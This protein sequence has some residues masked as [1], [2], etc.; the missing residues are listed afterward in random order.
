MILKYLIIG[1][2]AGNLLI[3]LVSFVYLRLK[4]YFDRRKFKKERSKF[5][6]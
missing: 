4:S 3:L 5:F 1:W 2:V 6:K